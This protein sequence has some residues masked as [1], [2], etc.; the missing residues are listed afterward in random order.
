[1]VNREYKDRLFRLI[2]GDGK[3]KVNLLSL[4][5]A[6]NG[7]DYNNLDELEITTID[8]CIY[9]GMKNDI[10]FLIRFTLALYEHQSTWN[11]NEP[12]RGFMYFSDLFQ[13][14]IENNHLNIYGSKLIKLPT[15]QYIVFYN[16]DDS[17]MP[18][19]EVKLRLS[20][21]FGD[22]GVADEFEWTA[23]VKNINLGRN[24]E[25]MEKCH[26]LEEYSIF[27]DKIKRYTKEMGNIEDA[28]DMAVNEC[29]AEGVLADFLI[30]HKA[31]V[32]DV[33]L[34]EYN[35]AEVQNAFRAEGYEDGYEEGEDR[36]A[37][38]NKILLDSN[39]FDDL[40]R[41]TYDK[42]YRKKLMA[43]LLEK[44]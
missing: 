8:D 27:I 32:M 1:M 21:A 6:L 23:T 40:K 31:E 11:P 42:V 19:D 25:L 37:D 43:E 33:C 30:S 10:S 41:S 26:V 34:T 17:K 39:R 36:L 7:T 16:G 22:S 3:Y 12:L 5:N 2:F 24:R 14:Y 44:N 9:M 29:I 18:H 13:K 4:Y 28:V 35:E 38:L 20:D 15:P